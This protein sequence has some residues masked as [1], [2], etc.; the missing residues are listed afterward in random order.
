MA[1]CDANY[2]KMCSQNYHSLTE[3]SFQPYNENNGE[4]S[5]LNSVY[6][7]KTGFVQQKPLHV[8]TDAEV[9]NA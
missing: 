3:L 2:R 7:A 1:F 8:P 6:R 4:E 9:R 5:L